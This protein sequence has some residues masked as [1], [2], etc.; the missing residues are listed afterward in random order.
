MTSRGKKIFLVL[1]ITVPFLAYSI[2][3]YGIMIKNAPYKFA[4]FDHMSIQYGTGDSL[5][6]KYNSRTGE[7]QYLT[8][9]NQLKKVHLHLS[10]GDFLYLH[11]KAALLGFWDF[12]VNETLN[13]DTVK[14]A[15][16][17]TAR[18][19]VEFGYKRKT[20]RVVF[21]NNFDGDPK[22][23]D[24]NQQLIREILKRLDEVQN[25]MNN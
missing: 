24:A 16:P 7:Y 2:Y 14:A 22:L 20:K 3:Y 13:A 21:D 23:I 17:K 5:L 15:S 25:A 12:P 11:R 19:I 9:N 6:N 1:C 8:K 10:N 4:E 18:Y